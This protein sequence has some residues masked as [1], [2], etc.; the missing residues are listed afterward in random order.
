MELAHKLV[1][2]R[3]GTL[4]LA[5]LAAGLAGVLV[6]VYVSRY[7][8]SVRTTGA[9]VTVLVAKS[10]IAKGTPGRLIAS[11]SLYTATT[12]RQSQLREGAFSD[13]AS[14]VGRATA[15]EVYAGQQL[16][17]SDF[18]A[19]S[20][21]LESTLTGR[22]RVV[23]IPLDAARGETAYLAPGDHVDVYVGFN[24]SPVGQNGIPVSGSQTKPVLRLVMQNVTV[25]DV[26]GSGGGIGGS[27]TS[28]VALKV[29]DR[30]A[31]ELAFASD[32]GKI[33]LTLRPAT[34]AK[35]SR[36]DIVSAETL[37]LGIPPVA[38]ERGLGARK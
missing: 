23:T 34:D 6:L 10:N 21:S 5:V 24:V 14:L 9:P 3:R 22:Q 35:P 18:T 33:W 4:L 27:A 15:H 16:T 19:A 36:P 11:Q 28:N 38:V 12:I 30:Q 1:S 20:S 8:D 7:R 17:S 31:A 2:S 29:T 32:N 25:A 26:K 13:P 37:L